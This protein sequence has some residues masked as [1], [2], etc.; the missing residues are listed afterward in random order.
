MG[1]CGCSREKYDET[2]EKA[3]VS[4]IKAKE[5]SRVKYHETKSTY[6]PIL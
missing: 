4:F 1:Q 5:F 3:K 2:K 6:G